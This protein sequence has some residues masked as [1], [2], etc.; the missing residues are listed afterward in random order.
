MVGHQVFARRVFR[1]GV[2]ASYGG[3][4]YVQRLLGDGDMCPVPSRCV[5][6]VRVRHVD[7]GDVHLMDWASAA[8]AA[9]GVDAVINAGVD[10]FFRGHRVAGVTVE[11]ASSSKGRLR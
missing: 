1:H 10:G 8:V 4:D 7:M 2:S 3:S 9:V 6:P 5:V 11:E